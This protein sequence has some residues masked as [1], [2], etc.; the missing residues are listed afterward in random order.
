MCLENERPSL[1]EIVL[2]FASKW[3][4]L[5]RQLNIE[6]CLLQNI[7]KNNPHDCEECCSDMLSKW[8]EMNRSASWGDLID[9][10]DKLAASQ[11]TDN[12]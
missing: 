5:G 9:A 3:E 6:N 12:G 1:K 2:K 4:R 10:L 11:N 7:E 8:Q